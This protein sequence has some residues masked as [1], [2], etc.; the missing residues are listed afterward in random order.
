MESLTAD[1]PLVV[2]EMRAV[3][4]GGKVPSADLGDW[5]WRDIHGKPNPRQK[6][7]MLALAELA[8]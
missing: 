3:K 8:G 1:T 5:R 7:N 6:R 4:P 2:H